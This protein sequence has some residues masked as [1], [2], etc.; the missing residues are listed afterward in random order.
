MTAI[1]NLPFLRRVRPRVAGLDI[2]DRLLAHAVAFSQLVLWHLADQR[3]NL[4]DLFPGKRR[5][6]VPF[7]A[8]TLMVTGAIFAGVLTACSPRQIGEAS[9]GLSARTVQRL[10]SFWALANKRLKNKQMHHS[11]QAS[12]ITAAKLHFRIPVV[13]DVR[14][15]YLSATPPTFG[16]AAKGTHAAKVADLVKV[17]PAC[18][19][20]RLP[21][22]VQFVHV[23]NSTV[24]AVT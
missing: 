15:D 1:R 6:A 2:R 19:R 4:A 13:T 11:L 21:D 7:S 18:L 3:T 12:A 10:L 17:F 8:V 5:Q 22:L 14:P 16:F 23:G 20:D 9:V 24:P